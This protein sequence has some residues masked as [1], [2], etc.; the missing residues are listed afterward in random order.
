M[1]ALE[2]RNLAP[3]YCDLSSLGNLHYASFYSE[4]NP[5][6][7]IREHVY[8]GMDEDESVA[9]LKALV[10]YV[11]R[12]A[13]TEGRIR[14]QSNCTL[15]RSDGTAAFPRGMKNGDIRARQNAYAEAVERFVWATWWDNSNIGAHIKWDGEILSSPSSQSIIDEV[16]VLV[17]SKNLVLVEPFSDSSLTTQI[18][19]LILKNGGLVSGGASGTPDQFF[20]TQ[21]RALGELARHAA[22]AKRLFAGDCAETFYERR[23]AYMA[24]SESGFKLQNRLLNSGC[25]V[26]KLPPLKFDEPIDHDLDNLIAVHRCYFEGQPPFIGGHLERLCL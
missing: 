24:G 1:K 5:K 9:I 16:Q 4:L 22:C 17:E 8:S 20:A 10:E 18:Y 23:L 13:L 2:A 25:D 12:L 6:A 3:A 19:Y 15:P 26:I 7:L 21:C 11:E 14:G